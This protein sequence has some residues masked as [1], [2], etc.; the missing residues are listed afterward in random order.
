MTFIA[1]LVV[2]EVPAMVNITSNNSIFKQN[3]SNEVLQSILCA[4]LKINLKYLRYC[5]KIWDK[6]FKNGPSKICGRQLLK[7][8]KD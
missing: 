1:N 4:L 8:L 3:I 7:N 2:T 5:L 6:V